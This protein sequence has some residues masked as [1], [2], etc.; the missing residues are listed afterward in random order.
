[1]YEPLLLTTKPGSPLEGAYV[2]P[3]EITSASCGAILGCRRSTASEVVSGVAPGAPRTIR[4]T[5]GYKF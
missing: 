5:V 1:M 4:A 3:S 2:V